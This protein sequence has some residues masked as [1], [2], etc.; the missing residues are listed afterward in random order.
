MLSFG[1]MERRTPPARPRLR[2]LECFP[3]PDGGGTLAC[4]RDPAGVTDDVL[5]VETRALAALAL[6]D[7]TRDLPAIV[8]ELARSGARSVSLADVAELVRRL[9]LALMLESPRL[10]E[11]LEELERSFAAAPERPAAFAGRSYA[12]RALELG[13]ELAAYAAGPPQRRAAPPRGLIAPHIDFM[14]GGPSYARTY[15]A[16]AGAVAALPAAPP[17]LFVVFGTDHVGHRRPFTLTRK[18]FATPLGPAPC[19]RWLVD[20]LAR[21][22]P[23][24]GLF[25]EELHHKGEHSIEFQAV[26]LRHLLGPRPFEI[27]P[28]LCGSLYALVRE[29]RDPATDRRIDRFL[30][31]LCELVADRPV[32]WIAAGDLAH[33]GP[34]FGDPRGLKDRELAALERSDRELLDACRA[35]DALGF[36]DR[37]A[38]IQDRNRICGLAPIYALLRC[39][40]APGDVVAYAQCTVPDSEGSYV[41]IGGVVY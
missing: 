30:R 24:L 28:V 5:L 22:L 21:R 19:A 20:E 11:H 1:D 3:A 41:S 15:A 2:A 29:R 6:M 35:G 32:I 23:G 31:T 37:I 39:L 34:R 36:F 10:A 17:P 18:S 26:W 14:R 16:L 13:R 27:L 8:A 33:V 40:P 38:A 4:L 12:G 9:D 25:D 7:G